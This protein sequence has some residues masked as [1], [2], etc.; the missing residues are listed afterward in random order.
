VGDV[1]NYILVHHSSG[2]SSSNG[3]KIA[4]KFC[5]VKF[6]GTPKTQDCIKMYRRELGCKDVCTKQTEGRTQWYLFIK[7]MYGLHV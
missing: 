1:E 5:F 6:M 3:G 7:E 2:D 4:Y